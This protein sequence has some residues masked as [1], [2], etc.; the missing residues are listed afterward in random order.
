L[1]IQ[2]RSGKAFE[3]ACLNA[4]LSYLGHAQQVVVEQSNALHNARVSYEN[5]SAEARRSRDRAAAA[6]VRVLVRL[7][8]QLVNPQANI[9]LVLSIAPDVRGQRGDVRDI[10]AVRRQNDWEIGISAKNNHEAVRH[11][12]LSPTIDF[13]RQWLGF[14]CTR[15]YYTDITPIF[16]ELALLREQ[17]EYWRNLQNKALRFYVPVLKAFI[18]ELGRLYGAYG[19]AVPDRLARY[20]LGVHDFYKVIAQHSTQTTTIQAFSF[21]GTLNRPSGSVMPQI[22]LPN[23]NLPTRILAMEVAQGSMDTINIFCDAGWS[24]SARIHNAESLVIP[25]LKFDIRLVSIPP[26]LHTHHEPW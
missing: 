5:L 26:S 2:V 12:R 19:V 7:E 10:L 6:A 24:I 15:Q 11:S 18:A 20:L 16:N 8:P 13:G 1:S 3:F 21:N 17:G 25:S 23:L 4:L 14:P 9:P 22:R